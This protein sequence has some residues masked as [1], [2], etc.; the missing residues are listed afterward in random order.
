MGI[1]VLIFGFAGVSVK[2]VEPEKAGEK[3]AP[4]EVAGELPMSPAVAVLDAIEAQDGAEPRE[5]TIS[6]AVL[7]GETLEARPAQEEQHVPLSK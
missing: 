3:Q 7:G 5:L 6:S 2:R 4:T 1:L